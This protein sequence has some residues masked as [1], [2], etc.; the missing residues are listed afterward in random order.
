M[1]QYT[2]FLFILVSALS[3]FHYHALR[4]ASASM[5]DNNQV[6]LG[7][8]QRVLGHENRSTTEM[9]LHSLGNTEIDAMMVLERARR[10]S[11]TESH[12]Q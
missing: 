1:R 9:Y 5:M 4:H 11:H 10:F 7:A 6:P 3:Y 8:I 2:F 12:A